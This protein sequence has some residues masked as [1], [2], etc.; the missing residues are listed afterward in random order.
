MSALL[1]C[2]VANGGGG[3]HG[4]W[5]KATK[6]TVD[7]IEIVSFVALSGRNCAVGYVLQSGRSG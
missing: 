7:H 2:A 1:R 6:A 5:L 4:L 3:L